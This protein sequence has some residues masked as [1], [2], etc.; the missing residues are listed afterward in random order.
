MTQLP[1]PV[2]MDTDPRLQLAAQRELARIVRQ[3]RNSFPIQDF[4]RRREAML[5]VTRRTNNA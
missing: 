5:R 2:V 3:T 4:R 1:L